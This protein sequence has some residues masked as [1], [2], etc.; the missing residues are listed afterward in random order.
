[1][2]HRQDGALVVGEM[3]F[4]PLHAL[5][6]EVVGRLV[7]QQKVR[8]TQ[9]QFAQRH[10]AAL[11]SGQ[12]GDRLVG[13][14]AAQCVHRLL[15]L[16]VQIPRIGVIELLLQPAHLLHE[17]IG[18]VGRHQLCDLVEPVQLDLDLAEALFDVAANR[19]LLVQRRLLQQ[20]PNRGT[21]GEEGVAVVGLVQSSHDV[22]HAG[23]AGTVRP[24]DADLGPRQEAERDIVED[25]L[26]AVG[27]A[28]LVHGVNEFRHGDHPRWRPH[29]VVP[30]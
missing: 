25:D 21:R 13:R 15:E 1:M 16:G 3:L 19:L 27:L 2:G 29:R 24:D 4:E 12:M 30:A 17:L 10:P 20:D 28:D 6:V 18:V 23:F 14:R 22:Q 8:L 7:E 9:Q 26:V 5:G 11:T